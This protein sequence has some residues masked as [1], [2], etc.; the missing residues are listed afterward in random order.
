MSSIRPNDGGDPVTVSNWNA[1]INNGN[2]DIVLSCTVTANGGAI[3]GVGLILN[4]SEGV[5]LGSSYTELSGGCETVTPA[6]NLP[7]GALVVGDAVMGV[8]T[9]EAGGQH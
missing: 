1:C 9:G 6:I 4:D 2:G 3:S 7:P 8:A 5:T